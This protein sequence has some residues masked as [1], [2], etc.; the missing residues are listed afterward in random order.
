MS[1]GS[2]MEVIDLPVIEPSSRRGLYACCGKRCTDILVALIAIVVLSPV[3]VVTAILVAVFLGRPVFFRQRR[4]GKNGIPFEMVKFRSMTDGKDEK[5]QLL[6][7][8]V[9]LTRFGRFLRASSLDE[10]PEL[11]NV[12][13]GEMSIVGPRPLLLRY[14][15]R[16]S[17]AQFRRHAVRPGVTGWAQVNGRNAIS[18]DEKFTFDLWYVDHFSPLV[19]LKILFMT[20]GKLVSRSGVSAEGHA[21]MPEFGVDE[22]E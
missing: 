18:W 6:P 17:P 8:E 19:D 13:K 4:P 10:L 16:Y 9:R 21:T 20:V 5:G 2:D 1:D 7:D 12:L 3:L 15:W 14:L 22:S 11:W